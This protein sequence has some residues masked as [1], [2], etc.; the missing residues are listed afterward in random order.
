MKAFCV[1]VQ[2]E[3][4]VGTIAPALRKTGL[5]AALLLAGMLALTTTAHAEAS[6]DGPG[7][8]RPRGP[9]GRRTEEPRERSRERGP[10][11]RDRK[12]VNLICQGFLNRQPSREDQRVWVDRLQREGAPSAFVLDF[13][14]SDEYFVREVYRGLLDREPD[15]AGLDFYA[16]ALRSGQSRAQVVES[17]LASEEF[18]RR[19]R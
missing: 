2:R 19:L 12:F 4:G 15:A 18:R 13:L 16:R 5:P 14:A 9:A 8:D 10:E 11:F 17:L 7:G 6:W 1:F 3:A